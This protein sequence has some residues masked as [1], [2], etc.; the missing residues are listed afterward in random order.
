VGDESGIDDTLAAGAEG[1]VRPRPVVRGKGVGGEAH[2]PGDTVGRYVVLQKL[3]AGGMGEVY[4]AYDPE[5]DRRVALKVIRMFGDGD[6]AARDRLI[7]EAQALAKLAHPNVVAVYDVGRVGA[8]VYIAMEYVAGITVTAWL[9]GERGWRDVVDVFV[10]AGRGLEAAHAEGIVHRDVKSDNMIV[11]KDGRVRLIDFGVALAGRNDDDTSPLVGTPA[12]MAPEQFVGDELGPHTDQFSYGVSLFEALWKVRPFAGETVLEVSDAVCAG[13]VADI[14]AGSDAPLWLRTAVLRALEVRP[15]DRHASMAAMLAALTPAPPARRTWPWVAAIGGTA[16]GAAVIAIAA[17]GGARG[18][19]PCTGF[20]DELA[21]VWDPARKRTI[22]PMLEASN[23]DSWRA[24]ERVFDEYAASWVEHKV[25]ACRATR[26]VGV[27]TAEQLGA[28]NACL[29]ARRR[30]LDATVTVLGAGRDPSGHA[31]EI[32]TG[33]HSIAHCDNLTALRH[34]A[35][36]TGARSED[37]A[38]IQGGLAKLVALRNAAEYGEARRVAGELVE[39]ATR[40]GWMSATAHALVERGLVEAHEGDPS[41]ARDTLFEALR[42]STEADDPRRQADAWIG[43]VGVE[44]AGMRQP[45]EAM[46]WSRFAETALA[47]AGGDAE[48]QGQLLHNT[49]AALTRLERHGEALEHEQQ[50]LAL[51]QRALGARHYRIALQR[52]AIGGAQRRLGKIEHA[53]REGRAALVL[54]EEVLGAGHPALATMLEGLALTYDEAERFVDAR[55]LFDRSLQLRRAELGPIHPTVATTLVHLAAL[56]RHGGDFA[57]SD[58]RLQEAYDIRVAALGIA[59]PEVT[60]T[61]Y[62]KLLDR[63]GRGLDAEAQGLARDIAIRLLTQ[64]DA[65]ELASTLAIQCEL[66]RRADLREA[67]EDTCTDAVAALGGAPEPARALYVHV[68]AART[69]ISRGAVAEAREHVATAREMLSSV[70]QSRRM[71]GAYVAWAAAYVAAIDM[72]PDIAYREAVAARDA[73]AS[74]GAQRS[75]YVDD[76]TST[77]GL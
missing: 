15:S 31:I 19:E 42:T 76:L 14:P 20:E 35:A 27:Q 60:R 72:R 34:G 50:A 46:R 65:P 74:F 52:A 53:I 5:L 8:D 41:A 66:Q 13:A 75:Y 3:G 48:M 21:G 26:V 64:L 61:L 33:M 43:L 28:R 49:A 11:G 24:V 37:V 67:A 36:P 1:S 32:A 73:F 7:G 25:A 18:G 38:M 63:A 44:A 58:A 10:A 56:D 9:A 16:I 4:S 2:D 30:E 68:Y 54:A 71:A 45:S 77:F 23:R 6:A 55:A 47:K 51:L 57:A 70:S 22:A 40:I 17:T 29:D 59:H 69:A 12:Y 62:H 39:R